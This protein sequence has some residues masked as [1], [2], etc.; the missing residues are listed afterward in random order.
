MLSKIYGYLA[1]FGALVIAIFAAWGMAKRQ[2]RKEEQAAETEKSLEQAKVANEI[3]AKVRNL[4]QPDL[5][6]RLRNRD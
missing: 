3:D 5:D 4:S 6:K 2:G 1:G